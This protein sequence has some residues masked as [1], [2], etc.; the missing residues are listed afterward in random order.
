MTDTLND[1]DTAS[2]TNSTKSFKKHKRIFTRLQREECWQRAKPVASRD[3][4][5]W[6]YD[7]VGNIVCKALRNCDGVLCYEYDHIIPY[8]KGGETSVENCQI[9]QTRVNRLKSNSSGLSQQEMRVY[10]R[11]YDFT[12]EELDLVEM[13]VYGNVSSK[14]VSIG[15]A[16][17]STTTTNSFM[18]LCEC[19]QESLKPC[20]KPDYTKQT[21]IS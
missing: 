9:L 16:T 14:S 21:K 1:S 8:S 6:R 13:S 10:S 18:T 5:R 12:Q 7:E 15:E 20:S 2:T 4:S 3:P 19:L 17:T 11:Q